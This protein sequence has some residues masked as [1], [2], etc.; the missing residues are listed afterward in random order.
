MV[1]Q[2]GNLDSRPPRRLQNRHAGF[3]L[4]H[5]SVNLEFDHG[6]FFRVA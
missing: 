5:L 6:S 2:R 1:T 3:R 4:N